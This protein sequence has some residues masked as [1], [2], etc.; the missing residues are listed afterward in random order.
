MGLQLETA[1]RG[2]L[3]V[4]TS[5]CLVCSHHTCLNCGC[6]AADLRYHV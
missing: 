1:G 2:T 4:Y 5:V 6:V 3:A